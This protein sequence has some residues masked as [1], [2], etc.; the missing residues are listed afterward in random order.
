MTLVSEVDLNTFKFMKRDNAAFLWSETP[1]QYVLIKKLEDDTIARCVI[2][3]TTPEDDEA[4]VFRNL[5]SLTAKKVLGFTI[6]GVPMIKPVPIAV[7]DEKKL[8]GSEV[9]DSVKEEDE[10]TEVI[11]DGSKSR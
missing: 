9:D 1:T 10:D 7:P 2:N 3:K 8:L 6:D 5:N 11:E 4:F